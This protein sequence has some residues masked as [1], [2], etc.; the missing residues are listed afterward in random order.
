MVI[1][2]G[3]VGEGVHREDYPK[4]WRRFASNQL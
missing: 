2:G 3:E 4:G 1:E